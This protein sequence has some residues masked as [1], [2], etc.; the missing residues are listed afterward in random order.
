MA[1]LVKID[2]RCSRCGRRASVEVFNSS[3]G[4]L[5]AYCAACGRR[6]LAEIQREE[7][8]TQT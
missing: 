8:R 5:G 3:N 6:R 1:H 7:G 2:R 4:P